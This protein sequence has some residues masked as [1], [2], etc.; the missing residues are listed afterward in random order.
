M[1]RYEYSVGI[2]ICH[3][4]KNG[5][6]RGNEYWSNETNNVTPT[7]NSNNRLITLAL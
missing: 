1:S 2:K 3:A 4:C 5:L 7:D 6:N